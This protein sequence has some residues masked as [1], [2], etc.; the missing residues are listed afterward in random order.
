M[1]LVPLPPQ[2]SDEDSALGRR[3]AEL[4]AA[5]G[6]YSDCMFVELIVWFGP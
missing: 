4:D 3:I 5:A 6:E 1:A 2:R